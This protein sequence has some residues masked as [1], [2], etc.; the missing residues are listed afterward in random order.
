MGKVDVQAGWRGGK[1]M[2]EEIFKVVNAR[3]LSERIHAIQNTEDEVS[4]AYCYDTAPDGSVLI[5]STSD[6]WGAK[7][8]GA[9]DGT[10]LIIGGWGGGYWY[11]YDA[12]TDIELD[13]LEG[14]LTHLFQ[15]MGSN[16]VC[17]EEAKF[18]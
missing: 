13:D 16:T 18:S 12:T 4:F 17:V 5:S 15:K 8:A 2:N 9:F 1:A 11:A 10:Y 6:W 14:I 7:F 3:G